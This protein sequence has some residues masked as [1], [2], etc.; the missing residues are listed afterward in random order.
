MILDVGFTQPA[1]VILQPGV[2]LSVGLLQ[3]A[4]WACW[5]GRHSSDHELYTGGKMPDLRRVASLIPD[6]DKCG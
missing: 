6:A 3:V 5:S 2:F 1:W 4:P